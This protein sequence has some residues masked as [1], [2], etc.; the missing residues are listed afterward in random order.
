MLQM[1]VALLCSAACLA[2]ASWELG[3]RRSALL[4]KSQLRLSGNL[5]TIRRLLTAATQSAC[6]GFW[7]PCSCRHAASS[8]QHGL[9]YPCHHA[10]RPTWRGRPRG[11]RWRPCCA[12]AFSS[13]P[14][15]CWPWA[16]SCG[17]PASSPASARL[18][19]QVRGRRW[20]AVAAEG[21]DARLPCGGAPPSWW[22][23]RAGA[24]CAAR[25]LLTLL[26]WAAPAAAC[27]P[28]DSPPDLGVLQP[29]VHIAGHCHAGAAA[30]GAGRLRR[31]RRGSAPGR[32]PTRCAD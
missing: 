17:P 5:E 4:V 32:Q 6:Q 15:R 2:P 26:P 14:A 20:G 27:S 16:A 12:T 9:P 23:R 18:A 21:R 13:L 22:R 29:G 28:R 11:A 25:R 7:G 8:G 19:W 30:P 3:G 31:T 1:L 24:E 10:G